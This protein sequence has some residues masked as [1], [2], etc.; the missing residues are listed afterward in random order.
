M[1]SISVCNRGWGSLI[2]LITSVYNNRQNWTTRRFLT[3]ITIREEILKNPFNPALQWLEMCINYLGV[4]CCITLF[5]E[6]CNQS[7]SAAVN[8]W[9]EEKLICVV[10]KLVTK[11][12]Y[13]MIFSIYTLSDLGDLSNLIGSLSRTIQQYSPPSE[14]IMCELG[15]FPFSY[16]KIF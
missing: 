8:S 10:L 6:R 15:F 13:R 4:Y 1:K 16:R 5:Y 11:C 2:C 7:E 12:Y 14:W 9:L 3:N